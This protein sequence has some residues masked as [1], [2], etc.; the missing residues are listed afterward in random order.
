MKTIIIRIFNQF[1][2][3]I[4]TDARSFNINEGSGTGT[5]THTEISVLA[6]PIYSNST[7]LCM[8]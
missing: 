6:Y 4:H 8:T 7:V 3:C 5:G 1:I 2:D